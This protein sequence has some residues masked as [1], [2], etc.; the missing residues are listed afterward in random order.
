MKCA[1]Y[2]DRPCAST[3]KWKDERGN[4]YCNL[5]SHLFAISGV[6]AVPIDLTEHEAARWRREVR[7]EATKILLEIAREG[8]DHTT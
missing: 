5:H 6:I 2:D 3:P 8:G 1:G 4:F 7:D